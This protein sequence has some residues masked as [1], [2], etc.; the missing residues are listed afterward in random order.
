[1]HSYDPPDAQHVNQANV[2]IVDSEQQQRARPSSAHR[3]PT[4]RHESLD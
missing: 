2:N 3:R 1:M 4:G